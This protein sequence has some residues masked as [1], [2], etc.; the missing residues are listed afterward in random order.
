MP[1]CNRRGKAVVYTSGAETM[2]TA[3][4]AAAWLTLNLWSTD[5]LAQSR[6]DIGLLGG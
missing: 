1:G 4:V 6:Y 5:G 2:R 3:I